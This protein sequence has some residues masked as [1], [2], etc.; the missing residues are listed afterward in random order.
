MQTRSID[1]RCYTI[2]E[3]ETEGVSNQD[4]GD[5]GFPR[6]I[7]VT[8]D[9]VIDG[10]TPA[11]GDGE[12][13]E[14]HTYNETAPRDA[15]RRADTPEDQSYRRE[16]ESA[17]E[18][19]QPVLGFTNTVVSTCEF[20]ADDIRQLSSVPAPTPISTDTR[21]NLTQ[22]SLQSWEQYK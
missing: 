17:Q 2:I 19:P 3:P 12:S 1:P 20:E 15:S 13:N 10:D 4:D 14:T 8:V 11:D 18:H 7:F 21:A 16:E 5:H 22:T 9:G 6:E